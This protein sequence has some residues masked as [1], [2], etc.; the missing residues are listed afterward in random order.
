MNKTLNDWNTEFVKVKYLQG[1]YKKKYDAKVKE[2][3]AM[4]EQLAGCRTEL[5]N[6]ITLASLHN[7][8]MDRLHIDLV[9]AYTTINQ[10]MKDQQVLEDE[11]KRLQ[12]MLSEKK[13]QHLPSTVIED[14][15]KS[16]A[17][18]IIIEDH[19]QEARNHIY[20][21]EVKALEA[22]F[23]EEGFIKGF[24]KGVRA[25]HRKTGAD[26]QGLSPS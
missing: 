9:D 19:V 3:K 24:M 12:S 4:E 2:M 16:F 13:A 7:Q 14:F 8:Q 15:K 6:M 21:I 22:E 17:F 26:I 10:Q 18:K 5:T 25:V 1:E 11:N 20:D 23:M